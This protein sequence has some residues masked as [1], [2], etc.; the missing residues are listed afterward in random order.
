MEDPNSPADAAGSAL[1]I[2]G[3]CGAGKTTAAYALSRLLEARL[4][5]HA[6]VD[7]DDL[8][9][10]EPAPA[11]DPFARTVGI[12]NL[13]AGWANYRR[14]GARWLI[15]A[16]VVK[17][18]AELLAVREALGDTQLTCVRLRANPETLIA[19]LR[20]RGEDQDIS[21]YLHRVPELS[22]ILDRA[23]LEELIL[24]CDDLDVSGVASALLEIW[25]PTGVETSAA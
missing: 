10:L 8:C 15:L 4:V 25:F 16:S 1:L 21:W 14:A 5:P 19:R 20:H 2:N 17:T 22:D 23:G 13:R 3:A 18:R 24:D 9:R 6:V 7:F 12:A 11:G